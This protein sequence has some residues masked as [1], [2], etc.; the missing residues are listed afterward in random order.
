M[1]DLKAGESQGHLT[2]EAVQSKTQI[3]ESVFVMHFKGLP[4]LLPGWL[5]RRN[6]LLHKYILPLM[7]YSIRKIFLVWPQVCCS[8]MSS[9]LLKPSFAATQYKAILHFTQQHFTCC[10]P[11]ELALPLGCLISRLINKIQVPSLLPYM[12]RV[13]RL[14]TILVALFRHIYQGGIKNEQISIH[15][16]HIKQLT[17]VPSTATV[18]LWFVVSFSELEWHVAFLGCHSISTSVSLTR[19]WRQELYSS[20]Q[21][22]H[23]IWNILD[24]Q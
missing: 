4:K 22:S 11:M 8:E 9:Y 14:P 17:S 24:A 13:W 7:N 16:T 15:H 1:D 2:S 5:M 18:S 23:S 12:V 10:M 6:L 19:I 21:P 20:W 3:S